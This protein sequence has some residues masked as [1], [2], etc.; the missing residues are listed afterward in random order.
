MGNIKESNKA[1][2]AS[3]QTAQDQMAVAAIDIGT[4]TAPALEQCLCLHI[5]HE[6]GTAIEAL[7]QGRW[8]SDKNYSDARSAALGGYLTVGNSSYFLVG[9]SKIQELSAPRPAAV[10]GFIARLAGFGF[11]TSVVEEITDAATLDAQ[12]ALEMEAFESNSLEL[13]APNPEL[14]GYVACISERV[15]SLLQET[16]CY[17][18]ALSE[19]AA[20]DKQGAS[21]EYSPA[22]QEIGRLLLTACLYMKICLLEHSV[23]NEDSSTAFIANEVLL[24]S[25]MLDLLKKF[26]H[27]DMALDALDIA[28]NISESKFNPLF[29]KVSKTNFQ[30]YAQEVLGAHDRFFDLQQDYLRLSRF[31][32]FAGGLPTS[33]E[34][35]ERPKLSGLLK[36]ILPIDKK[37]QTEYVAMNYFGASSLNQFSMLEVLRNKKEQLLFEDAPFQHVDTP[38]GQ[39]GIVPHAGFYLRSDD[40]PVASIFSALT[41]LPVPETCTTGSFAALQST[42]YQALHQLSREQPEVFGRL[43]H[44]WSTSV[45]VNK[46]NVIICAPPTEAEDFKSCI[47][48]DYV[49]LPMSETELSFWLRG[50]PNLMVYVL[51]RDEAAPESLRESTESVNRPAQPSEV[52]PLENSTEE[53]FN[54]IINLKYSKFPQFLKP[55]KRHGV[56]VDLKRGKGSHILLK[57]RK[58]IA[59]ISTWA[60]KRNERLTPSG[61]KDILVDLGIS[62]SD[63]LAWLVERPGAA[64][65]LK[66]NRGKSDRH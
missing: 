65:K 9:L 44:N 23:A 52:A 4:G 21:D 42:F 5:A 56:T 51:P 41:P 16:A 66:S 6:L 62:L 19:Y 53:S 17:K 24:T 1:L 32:S 45:M 49:S 26:P 30:L 8:K 50:D 31:Q 57:Y 55:L 35:T 27:A 25:C 39:Y 48:G 22:C 64:R 54:K 46:T 40:R 63:A 3:K 12:G 47:R 15:F 13:L 38:Q 61:A 20:P 58:R 2:N 43:R 29:C 37:D 60:R 28:M 59:T 7:K 34:R 14:E 10:Q 18:T 36:V 11:G 33:D